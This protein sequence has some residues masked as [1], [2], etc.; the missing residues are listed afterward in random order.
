MRVLFVS[1]YTMTGGAEVQMV[2]LASA[3]EKR[4]IEVGVLFQ[5]GS[6]EDHIPK[7]CKER[8]WYLGGGFCS[9]SAFIDLGADVVKSFTPNIVISH[10]NQRV[11]FMLDRSRV[12]T[13]I[14]WQA[15]CI[16]PGYINSVAGIHQA[17]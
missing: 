14:I 11:L 1:P 17:V 5:H 6:G 9:E 3:L 7:V 12:R 10:D 2:T 8:G 16:F 13:T 4:G 15:H